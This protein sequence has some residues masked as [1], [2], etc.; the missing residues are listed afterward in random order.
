MNV[1]SFL[2]R[3]RSANYSLVQFQL[4]LETNSLL[5]IKLNPLS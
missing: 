3:I 5:N 1:Y 4:Q 2:K